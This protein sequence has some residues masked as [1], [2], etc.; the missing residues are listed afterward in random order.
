[1]ISVVEKE[2]GFHRLRVYGR[3]MPEVLKIAKVL[4]LLFAGWCHKTGKEG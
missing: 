4:K 2:E 3:E 1:M